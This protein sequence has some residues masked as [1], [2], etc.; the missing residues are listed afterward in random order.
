MTRLV[1][2]AVALTA[3][4]VVVAAVPVALLKVKFWRVEEELARRVEAV[5]AAA[6]TLPVVREVEKRLVDEAVEVKMF[7]PVAL[8]KE[9]A[10][11][12]EEPLTRR[13]CEVVSPLTVRALAMV[14]TPLVSMERA[15]T[16]E[17][18]YVSGEDVAK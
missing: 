13:F 8:V 16:V 9:K 15:E 2:E 5:T 1:V 3:R 11:S 14:S 7:V 4:L 18:A 17:V 12:V 6:V 10:W